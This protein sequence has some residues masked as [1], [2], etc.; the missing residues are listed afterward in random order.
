MFGERRYG[1]EDVRG[2]QAG[3]AWLVFARGY[4]FLQ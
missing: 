4:S 1:E 2:I 3:S